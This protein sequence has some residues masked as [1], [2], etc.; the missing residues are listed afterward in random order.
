MTGKFFIS[1]FVSWIFTLIFLVLGIMNLILVHPVPG[2][3]YILFSCIF[4]PPLNSLLKNKTGLVIPLWIKILLGLIILWGTLAVGD[5][6]EM[7]GL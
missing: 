2:I 4:P 1:D 6:A 7:Y 5:L 3:F